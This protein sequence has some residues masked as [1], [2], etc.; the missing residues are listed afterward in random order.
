MFNLNLK[1]CTT[2]RFQLFLR[3]IRVALINLNHLH[4]SQPIQ[5]MTRIEKYIL[6]WFTAIAIFL[7]FAVDT[8]F[9]QA[10]FYWIW[11]VVAALLL[12]ELRFK[13]NLFLLYSA[14]I[15]DLEYFGY[16]VLKAVKYPVYKYQFVT[17]FIISIILLLLT[18]FIYNVWHSRR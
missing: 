11:Q 17:I 15:F 10:Y 13:I 7:I 4:Q 1:L 5:T 6:G 14:F 3:P 8:P 9:W 18:T 12:W 2:F 16:N